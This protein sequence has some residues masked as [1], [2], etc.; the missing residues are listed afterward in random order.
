[1]NY[2]FEIDTPANTPKSAPLLTRRRI[3][4]GT[5]RQFVIYFPPGNAGLLHLRIKH[6]NHVLLPYN[7]EADI[8]G[9]N[10]KFDLPEDIKID[11]QTWQVTI[12]SWNTDDIFA[13]KVYIIISVLEEV[14][15]PSWVVTIL[16]SLAVSQ[17]ATGRAALSGEP[18]GISAWASKLFGGLKT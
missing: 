8:T 9:D 4:A 6:G 1:M 2:A 13:H 11:R 15:P 3:G 5:I 17:K 12:E 10:V 18:S 14:S 7:Q 16:N